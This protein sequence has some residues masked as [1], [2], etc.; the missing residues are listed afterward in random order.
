MVTPLL[1]IAFLSSLKHSD[2]AEIDAEM[3]SGYCT[4]TKALMIVNPLYLAEPRFNP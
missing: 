4:E 3:H 2:G 1:R